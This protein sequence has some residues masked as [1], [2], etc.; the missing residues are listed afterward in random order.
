MITRYAVWLMGRQTFFSAEKARKDLGWQPAY[1]NVQMM[2]DAYDSHIAAGP[3]SRPAPHPII[4][5]LDAIV[6]HR[7]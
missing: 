2:C 3:G 1:D 7:A 4:R 5:I 6:P